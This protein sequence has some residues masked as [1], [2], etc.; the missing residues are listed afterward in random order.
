MFEDLMEEIASLVQ[1][2]D[3]HE[4]NNAFDSLL[5]KV[6]DED[7]AYEEDE[8]DKLP[9]ISIH[10]LNGLPSYSTMRIKGVMGNRQLHILVDSGSTHNFID[11]KLARKLQCSVKDIPSF[12]VD[13]K[14]YEL[15]GI[16]TNKV[17][18]WSIEKELVHDFKEVFQPQKSLPPK[19]S[20]DHRII[21]KEGTT[22]IS[23]RPYRHD[24]EQHKKHLRH[25]L[26]IVK[27][28]Q[29]FAKESKCVFGGRAVKYLGHIISGD[30]V[31]TDPSK[32]EAVQE[33]P[34]LKTEQH[35]IS[36]LSKALSPKQQTLSVYEKELLA[37]LM[38]MKQW[39]YYLI[40]G[41]FIIRTDQNSLKHLLAQ[42]VTTPLPHKWLA[43]LLGYDY[44]IE[45]KKGWENVAVDAL[46]RVQGVTLFTMAIS[47]VEPLLL[48]NVIASYEGDIQ[49]QAIKEK[50]IRG[51]QLQK[52]TW[53]GKWLSKKNR[54]IIGGDEFLA[55]QGV[56]V[57]LSTAYH[58]QTNGQTEVVNRC[59]ESYLRCMVMERPHTWVKCVS[60]AEW[61]LSKKAQNQM[62]QQA[63]KHQNEREFEAESRVHLKLQP[64]M[65]N[66]LRVHKHSKLTPKKLVKRGSRVAMKILVEWK[67]QTAQEATWEFLD[68]MQ[69]RFPDFADFVTLPF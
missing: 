50:I 67:G 10:A 44:T 3:L 57:K 14:P 47:Q 34:L 11:V 68:E 46:L 52:I 55:L 38:A 58:P 1:D 24:V 54:I 6:E 69:L 15:K 36:F 42:K 48:E 62:K 9:Q 26:S 18:L 65:Q 30:G 31:R 7:E 60:L 59:L 21:L 12:N 32:V 51:V 4:Y 66:T 49:L 27:E 39:H 29:L 17:S 8:E 64:Y 23:Q 19:R 56:E 13:G 35:P 20:F 53:N 2:D 28:H 63:D 43:E 37:I 45:Y 25:V 40:T 41:S 33:R 16:Q 5:N 61:C 22:P